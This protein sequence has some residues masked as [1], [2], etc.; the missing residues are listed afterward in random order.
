MECVCGAATIATGHDFT[1]VLDRGN[2]RLPGAF[3]G[4]SEGDGVLKDLLEFLDGLKKSRRHLGEFNSLAEATI[5]E[6]V[7]GDVVGD[8]CREVVVR[9]L[10]TGAAET[11]DVG[12][13]VVLI[14]PLEGF[15]HVDEADVSGLVEGGENGSDKVDPSGGDAGANVEKAICRWRHGEVDR[16]IHGVLDVE[17]IS[18]LFAVFVV[19]SVAAEEIDEAVLADLGTGLV[20]DAAHVAFVVLIWAVDVEVFEADDAVEPTISPSV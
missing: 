5:W 15:G 13:R 2:N 1:A 16:S 18:L 8:G 6:E 14:F 12:E 19:R 11:G 4:G 9:A 20:N 7:V 10:P 17:K 3:H